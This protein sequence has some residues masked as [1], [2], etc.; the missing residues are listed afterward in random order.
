MD[1]DGEAFPESRV[2]NNGHVEGFGG[3]REEGEAGE[4]P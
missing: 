4:G 1:G 3:Q 2:S